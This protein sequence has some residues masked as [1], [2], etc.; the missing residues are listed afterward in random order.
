MLGEIDE[1]V[2]LR[3]PADFIEA[4][5][6]YLLP[7]FV[8]INAKVKHMCVFGSINLNY[9]EL[10]LTPDRLSLDFNSNARPF[11]HILLFR[12]SNDNEDMFEL[13][14]KP[15]LVHNFYERGCLDEGDGLEWKV[16][17]GDLIGAFVSQKLINATEIS[18]DTLSNIERND[19][20]EIL[21]PSQILFNN[22]KHM[23]AFYVINS[24]NKEL[25]ELKTFSSAEMVAV[26]ESLNL[27]VALEGK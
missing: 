18:N 19:N 4:G 6:L 26:P 21:F 14:Y 23:S 20:I 16:M 2:L 10:V 5:G 12:A 1:T 8:S 13:V 15:V 22:T 7:C 17:Q 27:E 11:V 25:E 3:H 24:T 9:S